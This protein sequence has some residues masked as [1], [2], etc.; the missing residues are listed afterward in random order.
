[1][2]A[3]QT[4]ANYTWFTS[5]LRLEPRAFSVIEYLTTQ[6]PQ[7]GDRRIPADDHHADAS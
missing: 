6:S 5:K 7:T 3:W 2:R 4:G 1:M